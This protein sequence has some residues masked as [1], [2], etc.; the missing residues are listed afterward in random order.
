[1]TLM[2]NSDISSFDI[3]AIDTVRFSGD[4][5]FKGSITPKLI[6]VISG[7]GSI[8]IN[9][10]K[11][12]LSTNCLY[13]LRS[14]EGY[15]IK[16]AIDLNFYQVLFELDRIFYSFGD[17]KKINGFYALFS[18]MLSPMSCACNKF[19]LTPSGFEYVRTLLG[20]IHSEHMKKPDGFEFV[21]R[22][23]FI[24]LIIFLCREIVHGNIS[25]ESHLLELTKVISYIE[26]NFTYS[27]SLKD[28]A[29]I[30]AMSQ[31]QLDRIFKS[32]YHM[33][34]FQYIIEQRMRYACELLS[35]FNLS[36]YEVANMS[37]YNDSNYFTRCFKKKFNM[38]PMQMRALIKNE[39]AEST[40]R[41]FN[42]KDLLRE[43][44]KGK[45]EL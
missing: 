41:D 32:A 42:K 3:L 37:G 26:N 8:V 43:R 20:G 25:G 9:K 23:L 6:V 40:R 18:P 17:Y 29:N 7:K 22:C 27:I 30:A 5:Y 28:L 4:Q 19:R 12:L 15:L 34:P 31:R 11:H 1:M 2:K 24:N 35:D 33:S 14:E 36:I 44:F 10:K 45:E 16:D 39:V 21:T 13:V 38:S